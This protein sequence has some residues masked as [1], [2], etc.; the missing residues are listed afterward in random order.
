MIIGDSRP[1]SI[2]IEEKLC[3]TTFIKR[4]ID[5]NLHE[6]ERDH[7]KSIRVSI[8]TQL[9]RYSSNSM[10]ILARI[11]LKI[12]FKRLIDKFENVVCN[13]IRRSTAVEVIF[14]LKYSFGLG[15]VDHLTNHKN[16]FSSVIFALSRTFL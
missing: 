5:N 13:S 14:I 15:I 6:R 2:D 11:S 4:M 7:S 16:K 10:I 8:R 1:S 3:C 9:N 12:F